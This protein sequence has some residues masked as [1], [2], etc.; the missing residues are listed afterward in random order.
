MRRAVALLL[1]CICSTASPACLPEWWAGSCLAVHWLLQQSWAWSALGSSAQS[2]SGLLEAQGCWAWRY[3]VHILCRLAKKIMYFG[4]YWPW[5]TFV[6]TMEACYHA[7]LFQLSTFSL[8]FMIWVP[9]CL[10]GIIGRSGPTQPAWNFQ[11]MTTALKVNERDDNHIF[12]LVQSDCLQPNK[13]IWTLQYNALTNYQDQIK[14]LQSKVFESSYMEVSGRLTK[15][16][17]F[18]H[19]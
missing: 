19:S 13:L 4:Q 2:H 3:L 5:Q 1:F 8:W 15:R 12:V 6:S 18:C 16:G 17:R 7:N 10:L 9:Y 11:R 14:H